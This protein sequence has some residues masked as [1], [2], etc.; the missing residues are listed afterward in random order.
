MHELDRVMKMLAAQYPHIFMKL[1][2]SGRTDVSLQ[3]VEDTTINIP[4][5][6]SD[7]VFRIKIGNQQVILSLKFLLRPDQRDLRRFHAKNGILSEAFKL[8]VITVI[9]YLERGRYRTF[10]DR[11]QIDAA[12][13]RNE[14]IFNRILLWEYETL[15]RS[16]ELKELA[17]LLLLFSTTQNKE[18]IGEEK[19]LI[20][21]I[22]DRRQQAD[23]LALSAMIAYKQFK[24]V[25]IKELF[26]EEYNMLK[27]SSFVR[28]WIDEGIKEGEKKGL[29]MGRI[30][31][32]F[33]QLRR[34]LGR[35]HPELEVRI[36]QLT[37]E[38]IDKLAIDLLGIKQVS[39]LENWLEL[40]R[41]K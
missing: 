12:G 34:I 8:P 32:I 17:P 30:E 1:L 11:Y 14:I 15:I 21:Q 5:K 7:K 26:Y 18:I 24:D 37:D 6:R 20:R 3:A 2:F 28:E 9:I 41:K 39:E 10:P 29:R 13:I 19:R 38:E 35:I 23:L 25:L 33:A 40:H 27:Q 16:G 31:L 36:N 22:P 4:E